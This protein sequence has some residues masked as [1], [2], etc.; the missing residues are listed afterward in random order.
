VRFCP[1]DGDALIDAPD[2]NPNAD[3][4]VGQVVDGRYE[5]LSLLGEGG[6]GSVYEVRHTTLGRKFALKVLR[7]DIAQDPTAV[8][9]FMQEA[10]AAAAIGHP[11]IVAVS[12]FGEVQPDRSAPIT[13]KVPYFVMELLA[14]NTLANL[15][16]TELILSPDR[17]A[18]IGLQCALALAAAHEAGVIH[19]DLKPDNIYLVRSGDREFAKLLDFGLAKIAGASRL[20]RQGIV[21]GTPH[22]MSPEQALGQPVDHRTDVYALGV[23]LYE[24]LTGRVPFEADSFKGVMDLHING[25]PV[26]LEQRVQDPARLGPL[27]D[28]VMKCLEKNPAERFATMAEVASALEEA[29]PMIPGSD[30]DAALPHLEGQGAIGR[31]QKGDASSSGPKPVVLFGLA[32]ATAV[33]VGVVVWLAV[34][35]QGTV[36]P[37]PPAP[38]AAPVPPPAPVPTQPVTQAPVAAPAPAPALRF[39]PRHC[40]PD[41]P[42]RCG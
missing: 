38:V 18:A 28:I 35:P 37:N 19:R 30:G 9:R 36:T 15:L 25:V 11:N 33:A 20:T 27:G 23:I 14:G 21:F 13:T 29:L 6:T 1:F 41:H 5:V 42:A 10:K 31:G 24:C 40:A 22:Y 2:W 34:A 8:T 7:H 12:D 4:L 16:R 32:A 39:R 3:P 17:T 26:P